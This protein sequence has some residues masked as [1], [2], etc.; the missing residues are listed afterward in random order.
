MSPKP[1]V[2]AEVALVAED[3][4]GEVDRRDGAV[5][6]GLRLGELHRPARVPILVAELGGS[7]LPLGRDPARLDL[8]LLRGRVALTWGRNQGR[9]ND[10]ARHR[11]VASRPQRLIPRWWT[12]K[13][14]LG[15]LKYLSDYKDEP[16]EKITCYLLDAEQAWA[17]TWTEIGD[18][19][20]SE[21]QINANFQ[22]IDVTAPNTWSAQKKFLRT[23]CLHSST[24]YRKFTLS[25]G[26][27]SPISGTR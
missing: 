25:M 20:D 16:V 5:L 23:I 12:R 8:G 22:K 27:Q 19:L 14:Y 21:L 2:D 3:R 15:L 13:R 9:I 7:R 24:L 10:L 17:D 6:R 18:T 26:A 1:A 11:D 4:D